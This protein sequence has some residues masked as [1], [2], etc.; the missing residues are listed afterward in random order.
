MLFLDTTVRTDD[1]TTAL[2]VSTEDE[3]FPDE[4][5]GNAW[6]SYDSSTV[7]C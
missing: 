3:L 5:F 2:L 7:K 1:V 4:L 6:L